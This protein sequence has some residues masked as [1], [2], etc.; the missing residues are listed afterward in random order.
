MRRIRWRAIGI[1]VGIAAVSGTGATATPAALATGPAEASGPADPVLV[2]SGYAE[3]AVVAGR[4]PGSSAVLLAIVH[5]G[6]YDTAVALGLHTQAY[7]HRER[8]PR[9]T[10][11]AAAIATVAHHVLVARVPTQQAILDAQYD[12]YLTGVR[13]GRARR[14]G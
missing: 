10:S 12:Q 3:Q 9:G 2:W 14:A 5:V 11:A 1:G 6:M 4:P 7:L 13:D 8:A